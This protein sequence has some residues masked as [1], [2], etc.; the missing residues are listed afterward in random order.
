MKTKIANSKQPKTI[1]YLFRRTKHST[2]PLKTKV[3]TNTMDDIISDGSGTLTHEEV[4]F[5]PAVAAYSKRFNVPQS[6]FA[7]DDSDE[8]STGTNKMRK[9]NALYLKRQRLITETHRDTHT[10]IYNRLFLFYH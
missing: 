6:F 3:E 2:L 7:K 10:D 4:M 8:T 1:K 5:S 9:T